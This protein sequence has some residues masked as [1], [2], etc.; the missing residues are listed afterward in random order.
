MRPLTLADFVRESNRI[1]GIIRE[2]A[3]REIDELQAM[4]EVGT[5]TI[6]RLRAFVSVYQ[7]NA[8][9]RDRPN[10]N[11]RVGGH[12]PPRGGMEIAEA[13]DTLLVRA[14]AN[15]GVVTGPNGAYA[16]HCEYEMLHPFTDANGRSGRALWLWMMRGDAPLGFLHQWYYQSLQM[17][18]HE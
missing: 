6:S 16:I 14:N 7:P 2:P 1:E 11:V 15:R 12:V 3:M 8:V 13:L 5:I 4:L 17:R 9:L 18:C 10:L